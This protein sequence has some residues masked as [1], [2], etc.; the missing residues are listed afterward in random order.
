MATESNKPQRTETSKTG[1]SVGPE[2]ATRVV[3]VGSSAGGLDALSELLAGLPTD[4][5][6]AYVV[7]QHMSPD[8]DSHLVELLSQATELTRGV[9]QRWGVFGFGCGAGGPASFRRRS[10]QGIRE[11]GGSPA[12]APGPS[13]ALTS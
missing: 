1:A 12:P 7:A 9:C 6:V 2:P 11:R 10:Q 13:R 8:H 3:A 5:A 4:L